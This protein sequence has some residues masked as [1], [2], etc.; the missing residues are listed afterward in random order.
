MVG[1]K[2]VS[3][4]SG[5]Y[6]VGLNNNPRCSSAVLIGCVAKFLLDRKDILQISVVARSKAW[7]RCRS[8]FGLAGSNPYP[9]MDMSL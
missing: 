8:L 9:G 3:N 6:S 1:M 5:V 4:E 2:R 7:D